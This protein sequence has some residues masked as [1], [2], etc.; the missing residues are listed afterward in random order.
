MDSIHTAVMRIV[1][2]VAFGL[3]AA[4]CSGSTPAGA[5]ALGNMIVVGAP[6]PPNGLQGFVIGSGGGG[7]SNVPLTCSALVCFQ[8][9]Q[10]QN[11]GPGCA[12]NV[13]GSVNIYTAPANSGSLERTLL[14]SLLI[15]NNPVLAPGRTVSINLNVPPPI[16]DSYIVTLVLNWTS[17]S[18]S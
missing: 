4:G 13:D 12:T 17:P 16:A 5:S 3:L 6:A 9:I 7:V 8:S 18:C 1:G 2:I 11:T 14:S 15:P 10:L